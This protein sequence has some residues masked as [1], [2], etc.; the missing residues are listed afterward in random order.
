M[1]HVNIHSVPKLL[2]Y[3][4]SVSVSYPFV[5]FVWSGKK[6]VLYNKFSMIYYFV[7]Y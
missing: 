1:E 3:L 2:P 4:L 5:C 6:K 7:D